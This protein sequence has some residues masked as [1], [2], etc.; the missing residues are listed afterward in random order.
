MIEEL[1]WKRDLYGLTR[2]KREIFALFVGKFLE[3]KFE[4]LFTFIYLFVYCFTRATES[5]LKKV[6]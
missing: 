4:C 5:S 6:A 1:S 3:G 2:E